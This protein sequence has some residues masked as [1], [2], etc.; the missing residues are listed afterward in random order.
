MA[1][2][3]TTRKQSRWQITGLALLGVTGLTCLGIGAWKVFFADG[4]PGLTALLIVGAALFVLAFTPPR[5]AAIALTP[6]G[7][8]FRLSQEMADKGAEATARMG[9]R[10]AEIPADQ[11][12]ASFT[13]LAPGGCGPW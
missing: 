8:E 5:L 9:N 10:Y 2:L 1:A 6:D 7:L 4:G 3:H 12:L 11:L 13:V